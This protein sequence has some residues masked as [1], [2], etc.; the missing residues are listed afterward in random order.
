M[1]LYFR[2]LL[3]MGVT[4]YTSRVVLNVLGVDDFGIY[5]VVGGVV[6]MIG[7]L[8]NAMTV[9]T[10]RFLTF[11]LGKRDFVQLK[12]IFRISVSIHAIISIIILLFAE[13]IGL[14]FLNSYL[15]I[16]HS[17]LLAANWVYQFSILSFI[18]SVL[19]VPYN[20]AIV[21]NE[22]MNLFALIGV[23]EVLMKLLIAYLLLLFQFD[24]LILYSLLLF[25]I[26]LIIR[27]IYGFYCKK[28]FDEC[29]G[30][31]FIW[32]KP[33]MIEMGKFASWNLLGV[34][35]GIGYGQGVNILLNMFFGPVINAARGIA[36]QVQGAVSNFVT[37]FQIAVDP[38]ITKIYAEGDHR[39]AYNLVFSAA[40]FSFYL[41]LLL[42]MPIIIETK[43]ILYSW[44]KIVPEYTII[45]TKLVLVDVLI[46]SISG[47][48]QIL[49]Q[50]TGNVKR[51]QIVVSGILLLN[52]PTSYLF[53]KLGYSPSATMVISIFYSCVAL[54]MRLI[55]LKKII[56]FPV[57]EFINIV[58]VRIIMVSILAS[59]L[60]A[61]FY[62][63]FHSDS[64]LFF[65]FILIISTIS[66]ISATI[67]CGLNNNEK[68]ILKQQ[69]L[70]ILNKIKS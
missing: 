26:S 27:F 35:A 41:L 25:L 42:S 3:S 50:A 57:K 54:F 60:P 32:D 59:I 43:V 7:F 23:F 47:S 20:A 56:N 4:L 62:L 34:S 63:K 30:Y 2:M 19:S 58:I 5:N 51:Y 15:T 6:I 11:E 70:K 55:V 45:F 52:L 8:N 61:L 37:N 1:M 66:I 44:L 16:P 39:S 67:I 17:R 40:K 22:R 12:R 33:L 10:Q 24:K 13:T 65:L 46:G 38:S 36:F 28:H 48:L 68:A 21:A 49:V 64:K 14:W 18:V 31:S 69:C 9:S 53:L 29:K